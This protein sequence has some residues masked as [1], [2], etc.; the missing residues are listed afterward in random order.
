[1]LDPLCGFCYR[2]NGTA[3][4]D[5]S[6]VPA[7]QTYTNVASWGRSGSPGLFLRAGHVTGAANGPLFL[8]IQMLQPVGGCGRSVLGLQLLPHV[9]LLAGAAGPPPLSGL[10]CSR[11]RTQRL[12]KCS[13]PSAGVHARVRA[14]GMGTMPWTVNSEIYPLWARSTGNACSSGVNWIFNVLVSLTFLHVAEVLT[15][16]GNTCSASRR[17]CCGP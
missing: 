12:R 7:N 6:C 8:S 5:S 11:S 10:L 14:S 4:Y 16:Q 17:S 3:V 13:P 15:Y 1:M 9:L 2:D